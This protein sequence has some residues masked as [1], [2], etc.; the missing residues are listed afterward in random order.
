[1]ST[2][3][4]TALANR[5]ARLIDA[6][7]IGIDLQLGGLREALVDNVPSELDEQIGR[8]LEITGTLRSMANR[9]RQ[10]DDNG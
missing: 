2:E 1:M 9:V 6:V 8:M 4:E 3:I 10:G 7:A 5:N